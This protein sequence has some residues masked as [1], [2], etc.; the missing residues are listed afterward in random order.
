VRICPV[1]GGA[2]A[3]PIE[4]SKVELKALGIKRATDADIRT[5]GPVNTADQFLESPDLQKATIFSAHRIR[6]QLRRNEGRH[7][8]RHANSGALP[9]DYR[10]ARLCHHPEPVES[11]LTNSNHVLPPRHKTRE[12]PEIRNIDFGTE[13]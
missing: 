9:R 11:R 5:Q 8:G 1:R 4:L 12:K 10:A 13:L 6:E 3:E 7:L 2:R